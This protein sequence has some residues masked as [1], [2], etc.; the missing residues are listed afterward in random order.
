MA[1]EEKDTEYKD[2]KNWLEWT[3]FAMGLSLTLTILGYLVY[4]TISH[5]SGPPELLVEY[6]AEPGRY[7]PY[8]YHVV[9]HNKG[10]ETAES[11]TVEVSLEKG[12][13]TL[14]TAQLAVDYCPKESTREG[15]VS[16]STDPVQADTIRARVVSYEKP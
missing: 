15:W 6:F 13:K 2:K 3:V 14:E 4:K 1:D 7:E 5:Q 8:R 12:G 10:N 11:V 9:L 16:F